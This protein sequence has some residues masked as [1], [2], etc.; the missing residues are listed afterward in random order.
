MVKWEGAI[1]SEGPCTGVVLIY[2]V[3]AALIWE[4][5]TFIVRGIWP[6]VRGVSYKNVGNI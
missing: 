4:W 6:E 3:E 1:V 5:G 2:G